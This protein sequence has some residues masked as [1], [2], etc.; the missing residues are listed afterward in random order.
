MIKTIF[1]ASILALG[2][3]AGTAFAQERTFTAWGHDFTTSDTSQ[4]T[5]SAFAPRAPM[6]ARAIAVD[7]QT[8]RRA[9]SAQ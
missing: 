2:M 5:L 1:A 7:T 4:S 8:V 6:E 3:S 9:G